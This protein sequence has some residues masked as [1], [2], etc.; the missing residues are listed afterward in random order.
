MDPKYP[1]VVV[2]LSGMDGNAFSIIARTL[3]AMR[4]A[5]VPAGEVDAFAKEAQ[6]GDY[7]HL[8]QTCM[9]WVTTK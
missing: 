9:R 4:Q 7:D 8:L 6:A 2:K 1:N 3:K 5:G